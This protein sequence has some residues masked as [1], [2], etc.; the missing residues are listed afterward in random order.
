MAP[1]QNNFDLLLKKTMFL[2]WNL[3]EIDLL[4]KTYGTSPNT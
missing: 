1:Y 2:Y 3:W 4:W